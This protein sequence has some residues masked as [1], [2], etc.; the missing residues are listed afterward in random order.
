M[1]RPSVF[2]CATAVF[3]MLGSAA[4]QEKPAAPF[5]PVLVKQAEAVRPHVESDL[6]RAFLATASELPEIEPRTILRDPETKQVFTQEQAAG[7]AEERR[8][9]LKSRAYDARFYYTTGYGSPMIYARPLDI[10]AKHGVGSLRGVK[11]MDFGYGMIG[12]ERMMAL[13]GADM[14]GVEVEP[15]FRTLYSWPGDTGEIVAAGGTKG[16]L[17]LHHGQWPADASLA[18]EVGG[19]YDVIISKNTLKAGYIHPAG[20][21]DPSRLV[22]LGV[23]DSEFLKAVHESLKPGGLFLVYNISPKQ[24]PPDQP[25]LPHADGLFPFERKLVEGAGFEVLAWD[26]R[27]HDVMA[28]IFVAVG[29]DEGKGKAA[30]LE[31]LFT[32]Y[33][34]VRRP[35]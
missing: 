21:V 28:E 20:E 17:T 25:Y 2:S 18:K 32:Y 16:S 30:L 15:L 9:K 10:L 23:S 24:N 35:K 29:S 33:T 19:G 8:A 34:L 12:Q 5:V 27:D 14:H 1:R 22:H 31:N 4:G 6:A 7:L 3:L 13:L 26:Q 11:V